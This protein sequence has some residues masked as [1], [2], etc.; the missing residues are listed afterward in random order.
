[1]QR[2]V[3]DQTP[4]HVMPAIRTGVPLPKM[5]GRGR[6]KAPLNP[7]LLAMKPGESFV[8]TGKTEC[9]QIRNAISA[10]KKANERADV[11]LVTRTLT[12]NPETFE[13]YPPH[14][15]GVWCVAVAS[16]DATNS[17]DSDES[18]TT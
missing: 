4:T 12:I 3:N 11:K 7:V 1:M 13:T 10:I 5:A 18:P 8:I 9:G 6:P 2:I 15:M 14:T 17:E 16:A